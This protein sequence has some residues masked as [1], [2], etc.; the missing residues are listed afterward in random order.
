MN[1]NKKDYFICGHVEVLVGR[2][3]DPNRAI[4]RFMRKVKK[5]GILEECRSRMYFE[6]PSD[7]KRRKRAK[8]K[9]LNSESK[10]SKKTK[11]QKRSTDQDDH[12]K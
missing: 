10:S 12:S 11:R 7:K 2:N 1:N 9:Y 5:S 6:K 8:S 3:E 4:K